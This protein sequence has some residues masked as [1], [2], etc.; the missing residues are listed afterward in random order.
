MNFWPKG[1]TPVSLNFTLGDK[2]NITVEELTDN[3]RFA[4]E[5]VA[6]GKS[7]VHKDFPDEGTPKP[8]SEFLK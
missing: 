1:T 8:I 7:V 2:E 5:Q 3:I 6:S 4:L